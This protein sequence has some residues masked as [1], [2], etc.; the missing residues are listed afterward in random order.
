MIW[1][2]TAIFNQGHRRKLERQPFHKIDTRSNICVFSNGIVINIWICQSTLITSTNRLALCL[3]FNWT[4]DI[5][6]G[7][8]I[9]MLMDSLQ[10]FIIRYF[11]A[12]IIAL[13][14]NIVESAN[15]HIKHRRAK[16]KK[17][18]CLCFK[19]RRRTSSALSTLE[20]DQFT[21]SV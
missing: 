1:N 20:C 11:I 5:V 14:Y 4:F 21:T 16:K 17:R 19:F 18:T 7:S 13:Q 10:Y 15:H 2:E 9:H 12:I 6:C 8:F 3:I